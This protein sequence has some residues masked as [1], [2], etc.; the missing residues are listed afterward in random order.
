MYGVYY[1]KI[2]LIEDYVAQLQALKKVKNTSAAASSEERGDITKV[3][4]EVTSAFRD[5]FP[6]DTLQSISFALG[7]MPKILVFQIIITKL[8]WLLLALKRF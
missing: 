7:Y 6:K 2:K 8:M 4:N 3:I 1:D 5:E